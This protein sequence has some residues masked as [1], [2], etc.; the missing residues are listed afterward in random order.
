MTR[1]SPC[2]RNCLAGRELLTFPPGHQIA[3]SWHL[4]AIS[5]LR[6]RMRKDPQPI[7]TEHVGA[8]PILSGAEGCPHP[9]TPDK[10]VRGSYSPYS[11]SFSSKNSA[12]ISSPS[13]VSG[14][15]K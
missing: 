11:P 9:P 1:R 12:I 4:L 3:S 15:S 7:S 5:S 8:E 10:G 14:N 13:R 6:Q 2:S